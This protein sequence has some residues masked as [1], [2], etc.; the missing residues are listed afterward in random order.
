MAE[1]AY[2]ECWAPLHTVLQDEPDAVR[3]NWNGFAVLLTAQMMCDYEKRFKGPSQRFPLLIMWM[4]FKLP[5]EKCSRRKSCARDLLSRSKDDI[6]DE[7]IWNLRELFRR[8]I[9][10]AANTGTL[11]ARV[12]DFI[13]GIAAAWT[14]DTT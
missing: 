9:S 10:V 12:H 14:L 4:I 5:H 3:H 6:G 8:E 11:D 2:D 7:S 1:D 13:H